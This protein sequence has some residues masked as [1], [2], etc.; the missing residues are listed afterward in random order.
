M[1]A[2]SAEGRV[3][4]RDLGGGGSPAAAR[5]SRAESAGTGRLRSSRVSGLATRDLAGPWV[6][7]S[8]AGRGRRAGDPERSRPAGGN[9]GVLC[10]PFSWEVGA[11]RGFPG[12]YL[13]TLLS[14][15]GLKFTEPPTLPAAV[16]ISSGPGPICCDSCQQQRRRQLLGRGPLP[17]PCQPSASQNRRRRGRARAALPTA[18]AIPESDCAGF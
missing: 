8:R 15:S 11:A 2:Q 5:V 13:E 1:G 6:S 7:G 14:G 4:G 18:A 3:Q 12:V 10:A 9:S 16:S 17:A